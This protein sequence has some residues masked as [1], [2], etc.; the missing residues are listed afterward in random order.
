[1]IAVALV[2]LWLLATIACQ[3]P[4]FR[5]AVGR[6]DP[7]KLLPTWSFFAPE[8]TMRDSHVVARDLLRDGTLGPWQPASSFPARRPLQ[9]L[10]HPAKRPRKILSDACQAIRLMR[11][12]GASNEVLQ[13]SLPYL[14]VLHYCNE[15][16]ARPA[17]TVARQFAIVE[18]SGRQGRRIWITFISEFH[19]V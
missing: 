19:P 4:R 14:M 10:W 18:T 12:R 2:L 16:V 1:M 5:M 8:P 11:R 3:H 17:N 13:C 15:Q 9:T 7:F 6:F